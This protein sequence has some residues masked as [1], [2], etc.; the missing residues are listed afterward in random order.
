M[1]RK[2]NIMAGVL[3][4]GLLLLIAVSWHRHRETVIH[5][6]F[7][8]GSNWGA[9]ENKT[10]RILEAGIRK[11]ER[12]HPGVRVEYTGGIQ[13][14]DYTE[15]LSEGFLTGREPDVILLTPDDFNFFASKKALLNLDSLIEED[16]N[17]K[18]QEYYE[19]ALRFGSY[20]QVQYALPYECMPVLMAVNKTLLKEAGI[21]Y[22]PAGWNWAKFHEICRKVTRD[23]NQDGVP[24]SYGV[25]GY[26]WQDAAYSNGACLFD[27]QGRVN[28]VG[29]RKVVNA[30]NFVYTLSTLNHGYKV[31]QKDFE[32]GRAAFCPMPFSEYKTY[33]AYPWKLEKY[34]GFDW[35]VTTMPA[36]PDGD[37]ISVLDSLLMAISR[38]TRERELSWELL[39]TLT[40]DEEIQTELLEYSEGISPLKDV[41]QTAGKLPEADRYTEAIDT[42]LLDRVMEKAAAAVRFKGYETAVGILDEEIQNAMESEKN[43]RVVLISL[44]RKINEFLKNNSLKE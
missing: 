31:T 20:G 2:R 37:N 14:K 36:G 6:G 40:Y 3:L 9:P 34:T 33:K 24:D 16:G 17:F 27:E 43:I 5:I 13:K 44:Q 15:W 26:T 4:G 28:Y 18:K 38:H 29:G 19:G 1:K 41:L 39:K 21:E 22:P 42:H 25:C 8:S 30:V 11:F 7:F 23:K 32:A 12:R 10:I 35:E